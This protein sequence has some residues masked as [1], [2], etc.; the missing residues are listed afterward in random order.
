MSSQR[1]IQKRRSLDSRSLPVTNPLKTRNF[2]N[3]LPAREPRLPETNILQSR[4]FAPRVQKVAKSE[5]PSPEQM[6]AAKLFGFKGANIPA[7]APSNGVPPIQAKSAVDGVEDEYS[8][9]A[10]E[11][12]SEVDGKD[13]TD[14]ESGTI[15]R[16]CSECEAQLEEKKQ[17]EPLQAKLTVGEAGDKYEQEADAVARDVVEKINSPTTEPSV[18]RFSLL[19]GVPKITVMRQSAGGVGEGTSVSQ[20]VEQGIEQARGGGQGLDESVREPMEEAFGAD[21]SGVKVHADGNADQLNRSISARAFTTGQD[22]FF[23]QGEYEPGSRGGQELLAHELTH[24]VQQTGEVQRKDDKQENEAI[25]SLAQ[26]RMNQK[27]TQEVSTKEPNTLS[28]ED[29]LYALV[30]GGVISIPLTI[31]TI[32]VIVSATGIIIN[33]KDITGNLTELGNIAIDWV[34]DT[35]SDVTDKI[36]DKLSQGVGIARGVLERSRETIEGVV[37]RIVASQRRESKPG[38][39]PRPADQEE[40]RGRLQVQG[41][42]LRQELSWPWTRS[43]PPTAQ[44]A[45]AGLTGMKNQLNKSELRLRDEAFEKAENYI[46]RAGNSGGVNAPISLTFQNKNLP[47]KN[48]DA[49]VDIEV[50]KGRA[51]I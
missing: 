44:E 26:L 36:I 33:W 12:I 42:D 45:L 3:G 43:Q 19:E 49:R 40:H 4:P 39:V 10:D 34:T 28:S 20:D 38:V 5:P 15:Q 24:V 17:K 27:A 18:Q 22:I 16:V 11:A 13:S 25:N 9:E 1:R 2:S 23:K 6:E 47:N 51:F 37:R 50:R 32:L 8:E 14:G 46:S 48:K 7:F 29:N 31:G 21:F 41:K 35:A 30:D